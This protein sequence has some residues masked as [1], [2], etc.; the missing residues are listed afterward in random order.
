MLRYAEGDQ[1]D[2]MDLDLEAE[3]EAELEDD[4]GYVAGARRLL[5]MSLMQIMGK[6]L[7]A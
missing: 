5:D 4:G 6:S 7:A 2:D 1:G 3:L